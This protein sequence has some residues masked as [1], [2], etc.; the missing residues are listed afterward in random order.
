MELKLKAHVGDALAALFARTLL[1]ELVANGI[2]KKESYF[3]HSN[4]MVSNEHFSATVFILQLFG[5][6]QDA[7]YYAHKENGTRYEAHLHDVYVE[8]G[9]DAA[10]LFFRET[11]YKVYYENKIILKIKIMEDQ[12]GVI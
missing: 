5:P 10:F 4:R 2:I 1:L 9:L 6:K 7:S 3:F 12:Y 8:L 11:A